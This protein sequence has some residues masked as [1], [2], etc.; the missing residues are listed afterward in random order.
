MFC[1]KGDDHFSGKKNYVKL[2]RLCRRRDYLAR[3]DAYSRFAA[4]F[5]RVLFSTAGR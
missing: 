2:T 5:A 4:S 1:K 3:R